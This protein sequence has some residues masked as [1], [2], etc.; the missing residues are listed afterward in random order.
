MEETLGNYVRTHRKKA[1]L[2]Q[3]ELGKLLGYGD[4]GQVPRHELSR[5]LPPLVI[6]LSY[7][8]VFR[9]PVSTLFAGLYEVVGQAVES[10]L[11]EFEG[12]L[13]KDNGKGARA[14]ATAHKL[15]WLRERR[16]RTYSHR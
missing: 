15:E 7:E 9:V 8:I 6:A 5:S 4:E 13:R 10:N 16:S 11:E 3:R 14:A 2:S 1:G 12:V